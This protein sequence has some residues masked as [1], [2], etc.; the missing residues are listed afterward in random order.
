MTHDCKRPMLPRKFPHLY[1][2]GTEF[3]SVCRIKVVPTDTLKTGWG[4]V[5]A[6]YQSPR[7]AG[8]DISISSLPI[9]TPTTSSSGTIR[10]HDDGF[11]YKSLRR[12]TISPIE[13]IC[14]L[15]WAQRNVC[16]VR[17]THV[18][19]AENTGA[20]MVSC[21]SPPPGEWRFYHRAV[22]GRKV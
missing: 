2:T 19:G 10:Q 9:G 21:S 22:S 8:G 1:L 7:N 3:G 11:T 17:A 18:P 5:T 16:S 13:Q 12:V 20:D 4:A 14:F 15:F 6:T